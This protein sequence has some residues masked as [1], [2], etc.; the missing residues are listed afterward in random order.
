VGAVRARL[1]TL[2]LP[3]ADVPDAVVEQVIWGLEDTLRQRARYPNWISDREFEQLCRDVL[4]RAGAARLDSLRAG[5]H[6]R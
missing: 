4:R 3:E 5:A 1:K 2:G 6:G